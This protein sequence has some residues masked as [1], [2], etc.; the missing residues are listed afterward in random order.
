MCN[1]LTLHESVS[2]TALST[3]TVHFCG[4]SFMFAFL[5]KLKVKQGEESHWLLP[6]T[7][8]QAG[9]GCSCAVEHFPRMLE[10]L[11]WTHSVTE[12]KKPH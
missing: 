7:R 2:F 12:K 9:L 11:S 4:Y 10:A 8:T 5:V 1:E 6:L 3:V